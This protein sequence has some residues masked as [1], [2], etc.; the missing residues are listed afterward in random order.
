MESG[1]GV[2][3]TTPSVFLLKNAIKLFDFNFF[4]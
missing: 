2:K 3:K 1:L 4:I